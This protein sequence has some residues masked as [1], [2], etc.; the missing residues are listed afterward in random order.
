LANVTKTLSQ[1]STAAASATSSTSTSAPAASQ[2][3]NPLSQLSPADRKKMFGELDDVRKQL[4]ASSNTQNTGAASGTSGSNSS[5]SALFAQISNN[6]GSINESQFAQFLAQVGANVP[7]Y[8][9]QGNVS[10]GE[11]IAG[12]ILSTMA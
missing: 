5:V 4:F 3:N 9:Q 12:S 8:N 10:A 1:A 11:Q 6:T 7:G 2:P